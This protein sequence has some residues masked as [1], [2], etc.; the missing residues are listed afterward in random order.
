VPKEVADRQG[1]CHQSTI[2]GSLIDEQASHSQEARRILLGADYFASPMEAL[3]RAMSHGG[4]T[5][6][7]GR[8]R[9]DW[10]EVA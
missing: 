4:A 6:D 2:R 1:L 9:P 8:V 3:S 7:D 10:A 5:A